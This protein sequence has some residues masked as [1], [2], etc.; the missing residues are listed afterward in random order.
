MRNLLNYQY[1]NRWISQ[2]SPLPVAG[3][4]YS[5]FNLWG[6]VKNYMFDGEPT[7]QKGMKS[8]IEM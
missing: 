7:S 3:P 5:K 6:L 4:Y 2:V 1:P 8:K